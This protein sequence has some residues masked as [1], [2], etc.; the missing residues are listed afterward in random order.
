M[1]RNPLVL[2]SDGETSPVHKTGVGQRPTARRVNT[3]RQ[4]HLS[5][6]PAGAGVSRVTYH[7]CHHRL[8]C[9]MEVSALW[10]TPSD[11]RVSDTLDGVWEVR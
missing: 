2:D 5:V 6:D 10:E 8:T 11:A 1:M 9:H 3:S 7:R 4:W